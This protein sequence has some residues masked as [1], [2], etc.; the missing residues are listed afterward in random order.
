MWQR[1]W[2][3]CSL[4]W[5]QRSFRAWDR[6]SA[7]APHLNTH[8]GVQH[9]PFR[10]RHFNEALEYQDSSVPH[11]CHHKID[12][13]V[14]PHCNRYKTAGHPGAPTWNDWDTRHSLRIAAPDGW[15]HSGSIGVV[16]CTTVENTSPHKMAWRRLQRLKGCRF[17]MT[18]DGGL[19]L[20]DL[21]AGSLQL[22]LTILW[23]FHIHPYNIYY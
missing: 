10:R 13:S 14:L 19:F 8:G 20:S 23:V 6:A 22:C 15:G 5:Y 11:F 7:S 21:I 17:P 12:R 18:S 9:S 4:S 2:R 3:R 16:D 1:C